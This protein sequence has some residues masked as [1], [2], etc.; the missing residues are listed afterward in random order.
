MRL[1]QEM[2]EEVAAMMAR[3][4]EIHEAAYSNYPTSYLMVRFFKRELIP[5]K[6]R[7]E[8]L[9]SFTDRKDSSNKELFIMHFLPETNCFVDYPCRD[10][11]KD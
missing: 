5:I 11:L 7:I 4:R 10:E 6:C 8:E 9:V 2:L 1:T 3:F